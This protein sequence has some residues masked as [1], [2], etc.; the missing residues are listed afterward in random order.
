MKNQIKIKSIR[1]YETNRGVG[2][3]CKTNCGSIWNDGKGGATYFDPKSNEFNHL[4]RIDEFELESL[5]DEF[6]GVEAL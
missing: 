2:Y 3:E 5:I 6:E 4:L 1:Y